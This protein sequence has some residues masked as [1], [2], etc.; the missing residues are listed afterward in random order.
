MYKIYMIYKLCISYLLGLT[1]SLVFYPDFYT[2][3]FVFLNV[4]LIYLYKAIKDILNLKDIMSFMVCLLCF[5]TSV[6]YGN[7]A[8]L[9][10]GKKESEILSLHNRE[11]SISGTIVEIQKTVSNTILT[12]SNTTS[13]KYLK[14]YVSPNTEVSMYDKINVKGKLQTLR[15]EI[16]L[17]ERPLFLSYESEKLFHDS[18]TNIY[19]PSQISFMKQE[20]TSW[21]L[22]NYGEKLLIISY[23]TNNYLQTLVQKYMKEP[24]A[25]IASG[26]TLGNTQYLP[27]SIKDNFKNSGLIHLMVLSG[28]NVSFIIFIIWSLVQY[29][30]NKVS[31]KVFITLLF[32]WVFI[33]VTGF[34]PPS[35]RAGIMA[36][37][38]LLGEA[39]GR[40]YSSLY[41]LLLSLTIL[42]LFSPLSLLYNASL[43]LSFLACFGLFIVTPILQ[44]TLKI[45]YVFSLAISMLLSTTVYVAALS[46]N[47]PILSSLFTLITEPFVFLSMIITFLIIPSHFVSNYLAVSFGYLNTIITSI[48][49]NI[50]EFGANV[51]PS[52]HVA[53]SR[54]FVILYYFIFI[55]FFLWEYKELYAKIL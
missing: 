43:H 21:T 37:F 32:A 36:S 48:I 33:A 31:R 27:Q 24:Y 55:F 54:D 49:L 13:P 17:P 30:S 18:N 2:L 6:I 5:L 3:M 35:L 7:F 12:V 8:Q 29:M 46:G 20:Y 10:N 45:N 50:S 9:E 52:L 39:N 14:V 22:E 11:V 19:Y 4:F 42:T 44:K 26:V 16:F 1:F 15:R 25:S 28:S 51:L 23:E 40:P 34:T 41:G 38:T 47:A 53:V